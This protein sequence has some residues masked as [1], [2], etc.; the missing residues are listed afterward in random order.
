LRHLPARGRASLGRRSALSTRSAM[1]ARALPALLALA[2]LVAASPAR[3]A[4]AA[5]SA[6]RAE[7]KQPQD[8]A[9]VNGSAAAGADVASVG[10]D[11]PC[12]C[13]FDV[14]R[15]LTGK[16]WVTK[17]ACPGNE[18]YRDIYDT[19]YTRGPLTLSQVGRSFAETFC[20]KCHVGVVTAGDVSGHRSKERTKVVERLSASG[21]LLSTH[22]SGPAGRSGQRR[23]CQ[24]VKVN[25][26]L[27]AGCWDGTKHHAVL[28]IVEW[29]KSQHVHIA[30]ENV[31]HFDDRWDNIE[32]FRGTG[33]NA[34]QISCHPRV[35]GIG[36]CGAA[37]H[38]IVNTKGLAACSLI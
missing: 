3:A 26:P 20:H 38:E 9:P 8:R 16:Q 14:D 22:W 24:G 13:T 28:S 31:W 23:S 29:Y 1:P 2:A 21:K 37:V 27:V 10:S 32:S 34:R 4:D 18:V 25:S 36:L 30:H 7:A 35:G 6:P 11:E 17:P 5:A 12:L 33:M 19:A 15:T